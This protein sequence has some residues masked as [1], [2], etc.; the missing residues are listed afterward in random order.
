M[1][2]DTSIYSLLKPI[3]VKNT[4]FEGVQGMLS[5]YGEA[6]KQK[7][8][9][10]KDQYLQKQMGRDDIENA[11][12][13]EEYRISQL[14]SSI[15]RLAGLAPEERAK[16][17]PIEMEAH[18]KR[19][20]ITPE[21]AAKYE[22]MNEGMFG[23]IA[24]SYFN[25][26]TYRQKQ[27]SDMENKLHE[28]Q[29][30]H[31]GAED[32]K[33]RAEANGAGAKF[34]PAKMAY[35]HLPPENQKQIETIALKTAGKKTIKNQIDSALTLLDD[36]SVDE[37]MKV[38]IGNQLLKTL[39]SSEGSD[40]VGAEETK[41]LGSLL[42]K[43][44]FNI[45][46]PGSMFGRD[47]PEFVNQVKLTAGSLGQAVERNGAEIDNLY[48]RQARGVAPIDVPKTAKTGVGLI[49]DAQA[50][51]GATKALPGAVVMISGRHYKVGADGETLEPI[52]SKK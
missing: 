49:P 33:L 42:E 41:R 44:F 11:R 12:K 20:V 50:G 18:V 40:A 22:G 5:A 52:R 21:E 27:K 23:Q 36:P 13:D 46:Q 32:A 19:G 7:S 6:K 16:L 24:H 30:K 1:P 45:K 38:T 43:K 8:Q 10:V 3:E 47:I 39:N 15:E 14:G 4:G 37:N 25:S 48:G 17:L 34:N 26:P 31:Y 51:N 9:D 28:A 29:I 35:D 2:I